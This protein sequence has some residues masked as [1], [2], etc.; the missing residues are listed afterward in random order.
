MLGNPITT[1][2]KL[3]NNQ[4]RYDHASLALVKATI[5]PV[6]NQNQLELCRVLRDKFAWF[7]NANFPGSP[8]ILQFYGV[9]TLAEA[10]EDEEEVTQLA[11][12]MH[13][14]AYVRR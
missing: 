4:K 14:D 3:F 5:I 6:V 10:R 1:Q 11:A 7:G 8:N 13:F 9:L 12:N 2:S